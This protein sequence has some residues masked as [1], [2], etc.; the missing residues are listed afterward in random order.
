MTDSLEPPR[1]PGSPHRDLVFRKGNEHEAAYLAG[2]A[3]RD[4]RPGARGAEAPA[5]GPSW[6]ERESVSFAL[7]VPACRARSRLRPTRPV[8]LLAMMATMVERVGEGAAREA[9]VSRRVDELASLSA[10]LSAATARWLELVWE[11]REEGDSSDLQAFVAWRCGITSREAREF[12]RVAEALQG[13]PATRAAFARGELTFSKVRALTRVATGS[14]EEGLLEL[15]GAL[16]ASQLERALRAFRRVAAEDAREAHELEY[17]DYYVDDEGTLF[18]QARL[19]AE[20][21]TMLIKALEAARERVLDRRRVER[22]AAASDPPAEAEAEAAV[23]GASFDPPRRAR[24]EALLD[25]AAA[26]LAAVGE[27]CRE[28]ARVVVHVDAA[29]LCRDGRGRSELEDG[30]LVSTETVRRLGC[31]ADVVA[32]IERDGL[33]L[34]VGRSRRTVP[35]ALRRLLE[36]RDGHTCCFPGCERR[37]HLQA[38]HRRHWAQGGETSLENL[39]LLCYQHHRVVHEGGYTVEDDPEA[40]FRFR[41]RHGI[42]WPLAPPRL[43]PG[44]TDDL[45]AANHAHGHR[46]D[47]DTNRNGSWGDFDLQ[48]AVAAISKAAAELPV[49]AGDRGDA[50]AGGPDDRLK[51]VAARG[52]RS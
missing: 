33:P 10:H 38:H 15:A 2:V 3:A 51:P 4:D 11:M 26:S 28:R 35:P 30:P 1:L 23:G 32:Q 50:R 40:G 52:P 18:L 36:A 17:V 9:A 24:V 47:P 8:V 48:R 21:G 42:V 39:V 19:A 43:P 41:N 5:A 16:T 13:L 49:E 27:P 22:A 6:P 46:I 12:L 7:A 29:A 44:R 14:S 45:L 37:R 31:D 25:L 20:D 34:S